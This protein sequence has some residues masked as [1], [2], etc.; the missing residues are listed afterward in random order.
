MVVNMSDGKNIMDIAEGLVQFCRTGNTLGLS[1]TLACSIV[2]CATP[3]TSNHQYKEPKDM[4]P[5]KN[6]LV[7]KRPFSDTWDS[8]VSEL[9]K[10]FL[11]INNVERVSRIINVSFSTGKPETYVDCGTSE[12]RFQYGDES[13]TFTYP[14]AGSNSYKVASAWGFNNNLPAV[15]YVTR[16]T[17]LEG[18]TNI[19]VTPKDNDT[20]VTVNVRYILTVRTS[21]QT[22][23]MD[24]SGT[25]VQRSAFP[26]NQDSVSFNTGQIGSAVWGTPQQPLNISCRSMG[27]LESQILSVAGKWKVRPTPTGGDSLSHGGEYD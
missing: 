9:A 23:F 20:I 7:V 25:M 3:G 16:K 13:K 17:A 22:E 18:R 8:L 2:S 27:L 6:E 11:F 10:G 12:R 26:E 19:Y 24:A 21:G 15:E 14:V 1:L 5:F 4:E